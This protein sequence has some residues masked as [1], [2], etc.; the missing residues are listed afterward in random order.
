MFT[1][2]VFIIYKQ[3]LRYDNGELAAYSLKMTF[4]CLV[5]KTYS[6][7]TNQKALI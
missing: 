3:Q 5:T 6:N 4:K 1:K 2:L 7:Y